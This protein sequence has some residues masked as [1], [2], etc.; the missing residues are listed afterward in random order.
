M[1]ILKL[2]LDLHQRVLVYL[3]IL[4]TFGLLLRDD[5]NKAKLG[6]VISQPRN[7]MHNQETYE[8]EFADLFEPN[9]G[10]VVGIKK[11]V[12]RNYYNVVWASPRIYRDTMQL[13]K[14]LVLIAKAKNNL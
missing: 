2:C 3:I 6:I 8:L 12:E 11:G 4:N 9:Y 5:D 13:A 14:E 7:Y 1:L 10:I